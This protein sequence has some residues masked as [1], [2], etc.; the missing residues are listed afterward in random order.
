MQAEGKRVLVTKPTYAG[1]VFE[2]RVTAF[3]GPSTA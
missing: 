3:V 2:G 1:R